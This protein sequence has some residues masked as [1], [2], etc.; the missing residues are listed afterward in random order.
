M[1]YPK[2]SSKDLKIIYKAILDKKG[3]CIDEMIEAV[4]NDDIEKYV[5]LCDQYRRLDVLL[6]HYLQRIDVIK[7]TLEE[8]LNIAEEVSKI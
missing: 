8:V 7:E 5:S 2:I 4:R 1:E 3:L 6:T